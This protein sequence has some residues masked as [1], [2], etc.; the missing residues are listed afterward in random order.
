MGGILCRLLCQKLIRR[1]L[2]VGF[3]AKKAFQ[4]ARLLF[5]C[6][7][8]LA[9]QRNI[10][11]SARLSPTARRFGRNG[12]NRARG[13]FRFRLIPGTIAVLL[14]KVA[15]RD[16]KRDHNQHKNQHHKKDDGSNPRKRH[17]GPDSNQSRNRSAGLKRIAGNPQGL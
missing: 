6:R 13:L 15:G 16:M 7:S 4:Q 2:L 1:D 10:N 17:N 11:H 3:L 12:G 9:I 14:G 5:R 8:F